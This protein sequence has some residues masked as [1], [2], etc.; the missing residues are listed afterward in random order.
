MERAEVSR[1]LEAYVA[2]WKSYER[3]EIAALFSDDVVCRYHPWDEPIHGREAVVSS[4]LG[5]GA[6]EAWDRDDEG[7]YDG[8][9]RP[10]AIEGDVVVA[11][12]T[13]T[14]TERPGGPVCAVY[15]NCFLLRF[16]PEGRCREL[17]ELFM[18][19][20]TE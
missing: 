8:S 3:D 6:Y 12:G 5:E 18:K 10:F 16:D 13:S 17:T 4:W 11:V 1:W 19:R 7:T 20:P 15:D 9:Y 2:A 14:Y